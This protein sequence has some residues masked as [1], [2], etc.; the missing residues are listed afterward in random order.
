M[1][2]D[3][4][5]SENISWSLELM[6]LSSL[7]EWPDNPKAHDIAKIIGSYE[8]FGFVLP[9]LRDEVSGE[10]V[11]GHGRLEALKT[12][13][14]SKPAEPPKRIE[15][16]RG[17]WLVPVVR[18]VSFPNDDERHA[19]AVADNRLVERGDWDFEKLSLLFTRFAKHEV[20][21]DEIGFSDAEIAIMLRLN[22]DPDKF[23]SKSLGNIAS[24]AGE[25]PAIST[26]PGGRLVPFAAREWVEVQPMLKKA[27][28]LLGMVE[29]G[30]DDATV[31][32][33]VLEDWL[34]AEE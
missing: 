14:A 25:R 15:Y 19:Y 28:R 9:V 12:M 20:D 18:G 5:R 27:R 30:I 8:R 3:A 26:P 11:C 1:S 21:T 17:D 33:A 7:R 31:I 6:P 4:E 22:W 13:K 29:T 16:D 24:Q 23:K 2:N 32:A 10:I 34:F